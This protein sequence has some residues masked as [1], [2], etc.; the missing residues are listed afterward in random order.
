MA[1]VIVVT[2]NPAVDTTYEVETQAVGESHRV[3]A[4]QQ[5]PG[6]KGI[7]VARG[8]AA[9]GHEPVCVLPLG[10][11]SGAWVAAA[12]DDLGLAA[13][14]TPVAGVTR[15]CVAVTDRSAHPTVYNEPGPLV[16]PAE[17]QALVADVRRLLAGAAMLVVSGSLPRGTDAAIVADLVAAARAAGVAVLLDVSGASLLVAADAG[18]DVLKPNAEELLAA[19]GAATL[20]DAVADVRRRGAGLVVV[21]RGTDGLIAA[22]PTGGFAV[23]AVPGVHGNPTGAGDAATA[24][25]AAAL[26]EGRPVDEALARAAALGAAAVLRPIAGEVD[27]DAFHRF[28]TSAPV[29]SRTP[30]PDES[31]TE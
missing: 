21:S 9:L 5:R 16:S 8:L 11:A 7:N 13:S 23:A 22:G 6:G 14:I 1:R 31:S 15:T 4:V 26:V 3:L 10:G 27:L 17:W 12:L 19:T 30:H 28:L 18:A 2:P 29:P 24:G 25:L 20:D